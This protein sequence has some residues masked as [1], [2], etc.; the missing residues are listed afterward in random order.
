MLHSVEVDSGR[1]ADHYARIREDGQ[2]GQWSGRCPLRRI[3]RAGIGLRHRQAQAG[4]EF[5]P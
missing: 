2:A 1:R 5:L 4:R 3:R